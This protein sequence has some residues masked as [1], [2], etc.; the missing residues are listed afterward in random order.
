MSTIGELREA[1]GDGM[2]LLG[3]EIF[4]QRNGLMNAILCRKEH[5]S[6]GYTKASI[7]ER[8][9]HLEGLL[10]AWQTLTTGFASANFVSAACDAAIALDIDL[11]DLRQRVEAA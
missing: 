1:H 7:R 10:Y 4:A 6:Y 8:L 5:P 11:P 9:A 3:R 2:P